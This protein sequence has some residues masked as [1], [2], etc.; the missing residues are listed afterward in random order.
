MARIVFVAHTQRPGAVELAAEMAKAL[1]A[2][3]HEVP[4]VEIPA[5]GTSADL[6]PLDL[7]VSLGGDGTMLRTVDLV[8]QADV[9]VLGVNLGQLGYLSAVEPVSYTHLTLPTNREV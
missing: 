2:E 1:Q 4:L 5:D 3:G 9:P 6:G 8:S 7:A